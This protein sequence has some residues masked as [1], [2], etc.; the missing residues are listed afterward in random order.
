MH[1]AFLKK[2]FDRRFLP[3]RDECVC[4]GFIFCSSPG[5]PTGRAAVYAKQGNLYFIE[6]LRDERNMQF[7]IF[8]YNFAGYSIQVRPDTRSDGVTTA[9][10]DSLPGMPCINFS[11]SFLYL[12][13]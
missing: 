4:N 3:V 12:H 7:K 5:I 6:N 13:P 8:T 10:A 9:C 11:N 1:N 2:R